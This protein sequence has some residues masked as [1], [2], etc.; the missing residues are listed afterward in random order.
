MSIERKER[1]RVM[2][3][4]LLA[5]LPAVVMGWLV[6]SCWVNVPF[7]DEWDISTVFERYYSHTLDVHFLMSQHNEHRYPLLRL[8]TLVAGL[9]SHGDVRVHM[10]LSL[11]LCALI[12]LHL[13]LLLRRYSGLSLHT[14]LLLMFF[15]NLLL[16]SPVQ[17]F[18]FLMGMQWCF[19]VPPLLLTA[20][21]L[22]YLTG[23]PFPLKVLGVS[24][25]SL[26]STFA[27]GNGMLLWALLFPFNILFNRQKRPLSHLLSAGAYLLA[28][29]LAVGVYFHGYQKP[30]HHPSLLESFV[31]PGES[32][33]FLLIWIGAPLTPGFSPDAYELAMVPGMVILAAFSLV[34][35]CTVYT[36]LMKDERS[37]ALYPWAVTGLYALLTGLV[38]A[39]TRA[40][41]GL[42]HAFLS[43][44]TSV[45]VFLL[46]SLVV[47]LCLIYFLF[48]SRRERT[49]Q[50][51]LAFFSVPLVILHLSVCSC[52][53]AAM[54]QHRNELLEGM[55]A[56]RFCRIM[57]QN[58]KLDYLYPSN[59]GH[60]IERFEALS[61]LGLTG[62]KPEEP[63]S[64]DLLS[65]AD[66]TGHGEYGC[67]DLCRM[68]EDRMLE[69]G[70][71]A[72]D[73]K[74]GI[75]A[76]YVLI[77]Y[78]NRSGEV[79]PLTV[80]RPCYRRPDVVRVHR[81]ET[82]LLSGFYSLIDSQVL[83]E[84]E[85]TLSAWY[86]DRAGRRVFQL[87]QTFVMRING[88]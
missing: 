42:P 65:S 45:S 34:L 78:S 17:W 71:W 1:V 86:F 75:P 52:S 16:F 47:A 20:G 77:A 27:L 79:K 88:N 31:H 73:V 36:I 12:S 37:R 41:H 59:P 38:T 70:G 72:A 39:V 6:V 61:A 83:P 54:E 11:V 64:L 55:T 44:Y 50:A 23:W 49:L 21:L 35:V 46:I 69:A 66:R 14:M 30:P 53:R 3:A 28:A 58:R 9:A 85:V 19:F 51:G 10:A 4:A 76:Q 67:F 68:R 15:V 8:F 13:Y 22:M 25:L 62:I 82:M 26:V 84:G 43:R 63:E 33:A 29:L 81:K 2:V 40:G 80:L 48:F 87:A 7:Y 18:N 74:N 24:L 32:L 57:P 5:V 60:L 56:L